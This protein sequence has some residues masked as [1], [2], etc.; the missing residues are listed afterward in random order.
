MA[1]QSAHLTTIDKSQQSLNPPA[2]TVLEIQKVT[3]AFGD[4][5]AVREFSLSIQRGE[6][7][8]LLGGSGSGKSTLLRML[9]GFEAL[10][11]GAILLDGKD[12]AGT[13][14]HKLPF[15]M[16]FQ[17]Y[18]LFPHMNVEKNIAY[19]LKQDRIPAAEIRLRVNELLRLVHMEEFCKRM[20]HQL[21]GGQRQRVALARSLAKRPQLLLLDEPMGALDKKLR[22]EMQLEVVDII[23]QVGVTCVMVTH[24]Q[25]EAMTMADRVGIMNQGELVQVGTPHDIYEFPRSRFTAEFIGSVNLFDGKVIEEE[26]DHVIVDAN[27][28]DQPI[29]IDHSILGPA[30]QHVSVAIR[31]EKMHLS[32]ERPQTEVNWAQGTI[33]EIAYLGGHSIYHIELSS[34]LVLQ[35]VRYN[36]ERREVQYKLHDSVYVSWSSGSAVVL[37]S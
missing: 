8:A 7:F 27:Y 21:S 34:N 33:S 35:A 10:T 4:T 20:P 11:S 31:P 6:I 32:K 15:N 5:I 13:P 9:A 25:E 23:K 26:P 36:A 17:S 3:K 16:M 28:I 37:E 12:V 2:D 29:Y 30:G 18:A 22:N 1:N 24:D 14:P 19:G